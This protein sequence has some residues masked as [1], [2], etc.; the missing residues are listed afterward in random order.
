MRAYPLA[1]LL[2]ALRPQQPVRT[3]QSPVRGVTV[4]S[5]RCW[6]GDLFFALPG[7]RTDGHRFVQRALSAGA[8]AAVVGADFSGEGR[9]IR[10]DDPLSALQRLAAWYRRTH[11]QTVIAITGSNGKTIVKDALIRLLAGQTVY[12]SPGSHNSQLGP[13]SQSPEFAADKT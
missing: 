5:R 1:S 13:S 3:T 10:V 12:G 9:L 11:L 8:V 4:D 2:P 7:Q 6:P